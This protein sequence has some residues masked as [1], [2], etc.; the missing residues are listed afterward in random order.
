MSRGE[1]LRQI[2]GY[3]DGIVGRC[4]EPEGNRIELW[5]PRQAAS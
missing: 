4:V 5:Q 1:K 3:D 2:D